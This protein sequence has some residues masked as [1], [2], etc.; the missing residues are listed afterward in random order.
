MFKLLLLKTDVSKSPPSII[1]PLI[2]SKCFLI[3]FLSLI[4]VFIGNILMPTKCVS[5]SKLIVDLDGSI[6][7]F[8]CGFVLFLE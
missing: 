4:K 2:G 1:M 6:K 7:E 3:A 5:I 8:K